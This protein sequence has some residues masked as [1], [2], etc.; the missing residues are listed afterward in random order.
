MK[1][2]IGQAVTRREDDRLLTGAGKYADD[3]RFTNESHLVLLRSPHA[4]ARILSIDTAAAQAAPDVLAIFTGAQLVADG[5]KAMRDAV[6]IPVTVKHRIGVD[7]DESYG[8]VRDFV[9]TVAQA[10]CEVFTVHARNAWL[11]GLSPKENREIPPLRHEMVHR[12]KTDFPSLT[13]CINGG[14]T[15]P[16][17]IALQLDHIDGVMVGREAYHNPWIMAGWDETFF[18]AAPVIRDRSDVERHMIDYM[19]R[20]TA[21]GEPWSRVSRHMLGLWNGTAGARRWRQVWSDHR[22]KNAPPHEVARLA[23]EARLHG[24]MA[25]EPVGL[26]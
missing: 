14:V 15:T 3:L 7:Q 13:I 4:H 12:L 22:L 18:G 17:Q 5:V 6:S 9:G 1:F 2:G 10:G 11:K 20:C 21:A 8:F 16:A 24:A 19:S 23:T 25:K 26:D